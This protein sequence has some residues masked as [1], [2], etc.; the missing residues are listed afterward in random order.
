MSVKSNKKGRQSKPN[1][2]I[3]SFTLVHSPSNEKSSDHVE[4]S[5][6]NGGRKM[7]EIEREEKGFGSRKREREKE[8]ER[9]YVSRHPSRYLLTSHIHVMNWGGGLSLHYAPNT[10]SISR[11]WWGYDKICV[12]NDNKSRDWIVQIPEMWMDKRNE[13]R[14]IFLLHNSQ[15]IIPNHPISSRKS[16]RE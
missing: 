3:L 6:E 16:A 13:I 4:I 15:S 5:E 11:F 2:I 9:W 10:C 8:I 7:W 14:L 1:K 12:I